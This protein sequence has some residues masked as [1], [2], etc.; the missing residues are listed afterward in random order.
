LLETPDEA[1]REAVE[2]G[3]PG[4]ERSMAAATRVLEGLGIADPS[5]VLNLQAS[6]ENQSGGE[7]NLLKVMVFEALRRSKLDQDY[8]TEV[9][10]TFA[11]PGETFDVAFG[12]LT[13]PRR[14]VVLRARPDSGTRTAAVAMI[15][16]ITR[17]EIVQP[18]YL[19]LG[20][21]GFP[22]AA[23]ASERSQA[24]L[25]DLSVIGEE[26]DLPP[27]FG[28]ALSAAS[29]V[30]D[31]AGSH[32]IVIVEP[33]QWDRI[34][35]YVRTDLVH[36][37]EAPASELVA[38]KWLEYHASAHDFSH[39]F[40]TSE[41]QGLLTGA[42]PR[43][44]VEIAQLIRTAVTPGF[45]PPPI[46]GGVKAGDVDFQRRVESVVAA[47]EQWRSQLLTWHMTSGRTAFERNFLLA[48]AV[49]RGFPVGAAYKE[50]KRLCAK[51]GDVADGVSGHSGPGVIELLNTVQADLAHDGRVHFPRPRW[52]E[53]VL[54]YYWVDR[55]DGHDEFISWLIRLPRSDSFLSEERPDVVRRVS[56]VVAGLVL[57]PERIDRLGDVIDL[58][59]AQEELRA[60]AW[61]FLDAAS[62]DLR[63][64]RSVAQTMLRWST[65]RD[66]QRRRAVAWVCG[67][68]FGQVS[69]GKA[70]VRLGHL[71]ESGEPEVVA[72]AERAVVALWERSAI[73]HELLAQLVKWGSD[74]T[75]TRVRAARNIFVTIAAIP[76]SSDASRPDL[77]VRAMADVEALDLVAKG[78]RDLL[79]SDMRSD[80]LV[81]ALRPWF[82]ACRM[83]PDSAR[84]DVLSVFE[85]V[86]AGSRSAHERLQK[87][88]YL[89][90]GST[91]APDFSP[92]GRLV[93]EVERL[94]QPQPD[95]AVSS[96][97]ANED[98]AE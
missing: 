79:A 70:L 80:E 59:S 34:G 22:T 7:I 3:D 32:L 68:E 31:N 74:G 93:R 65:G 69:T 64:G 76:S 19:R 39:W 55:P 54:D 53:S 40:A 89:W 16:R 25:M 90:H 42:T 26:S 8:L 61:E 49:L 56:D 50:A 98:P 62:L 46:A 37:L 35:R 41:I 44:A 33:R 51:L 10:R 2:V 13:G 9:C 15:E 66:V 52:A 47:R 96:D 57:T 4:R 30:L 75:A 82:E 85:R 71:I 21:N 63:L 78:W 77:L 17:E 45:V 6:V 72:E 1:A 88:V 67:R 36:D 92:G 95:S 91:R 81:A 28:P 20:S 84:V 48:T 23:L 94:A 97:T 11:E 83:S 18:H 60:A 29:D 73:G 5:S 86:T 12:V 58:W 27:D 43:E 38:R 87:C 14:L 24:Y